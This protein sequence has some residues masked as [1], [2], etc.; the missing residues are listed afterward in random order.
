MA[1]LEKERLSRINSSRFLSDRQAQ[2]YTS[3]SQDQASRKEDERRETLVTE[4]D[5]NISQ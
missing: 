4:S 1:A 3:R 2:L 5:F